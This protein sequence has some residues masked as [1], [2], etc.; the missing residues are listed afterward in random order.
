MSSPDKSLT[1]RPS[2]VSLLHQ[3]E[4][5]EA[6]LRSLLNSVP[7]II[8]M[9]DRE[10]NILA[11]HS[12]VLRNAG[13]DLTRMTGVNWLDFI[14]PECKAEV[15]QAIDT[16]FE[17][18]QSSGFEASTYEGVWYESQIAPIY[19]NGKVAAATVISVDITSRKKAE[20][21][22]RGSEEHMRSLLEN[23]PGIIT[24]IDRNGT[25]Q[26]MHSADLKARGADLD[27][28]IGRS[29]YD[30]VPLTD[31]ERT[32]LLIQQVFRT[33][34]PT[35]YETL[36]ANER[37]YQT[38]IMPVVQGNEAI[39]LTMISLDIHERKKVEEEL[40]RAKDAAEAANRAKSAFLA[41]MSHELRTPL[42]A[43][44]GF[45]QLMERDRSIT[46]MQQE[47]LAIIS[48]S[49][50][51]L[52]NLIN[53]V[54][55]MSKIEAGR[56]TLHPT[57]F[58]LFR[59][60]DSLESMFRARAESKD[61]ELNFVRSESVLQYIRT[62]ESKL[63]Q[64]LI[65]LIGNALKFTDAGYVNVIAHGFDVESTAMRITF[66]VEDSGPGIS[67]SDLPNVFDMF[68]QTRSNRLS[69]EGTGLGLAISRQFVRLM[70]G[71][72]S[73][74]S[75]VGKGSKF[76]FDIEIGLALPQ[77]V[78]TT[79]TI[80]RV[81]GLEANQ[82]T[83]RILVAEDKWE[84]RILLVRLLQ[85]IGF[86]VRDATNG[87]ECIEAWLQWKPHLILMDM[88]MPVMDGYEATRQIKGQTE[89]EKPVIIAMSASVF[90]H[91][92]AATSAAGCDDFISKPFREDH[93]FEKIAEHL[94]VR[95][96]YQ[97]PLQSA[98]VPDNKAKKRLVSADLAMLS[99]PWLHELYQAAVIADLQKANQLI[100]QIQPDHPA[101]ATGLTE[102][103]NAFRF[104]TIATLVKPE[105]TR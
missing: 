52:L 43:I 3:F 69:Q 56:I 38:R 41:N 76:I 23:I 90:E 58:D 44:L 30:L 61:L 19:E 53:D 98:T 55:E 92:R 6:Q 54:L 42:N 10:G 36:G 45:A 24:T 91:E 57:D 39:A 17:T 78:R 2:F 62:D 66:S 51:H 70:G 93:V 73:V 13:L 82:P 85:T 60:L 68:M 5:S 28:Y 103:V 46:K 29:V 88:R 21:S 89:S 26:S 1:T 8:S 80:Q 25:I 101:I 83:Y 12:A 15:R 81:I 22:L 14:V 48:R 40:R 97:Q 47:N 32:G 37:W 27:Q 65:N 99:K 20:E 59:M 96:I 86:D 72:I 7:G 9:I 75:E 4:Q 95:F 74:E 84:N 79:Q 71:D 50:E 77:H 49:G 67:P 35:T 87:K 64:V 11:M 94:Q 34:L 18:Q 104:D 16:V 105:G 63:R 100:A 33:K 102:L 31:R